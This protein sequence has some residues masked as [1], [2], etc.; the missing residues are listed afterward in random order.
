MLDLRRGRIWNDAG[1]EMKRPRTAS[2]EIWLAQRPADQNRKIKT[3]SIS[4][5]KKYPVMMVALKQEEAHE[6]SL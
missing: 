4:E 3:G 1:W 5:I 6:R 2:Q